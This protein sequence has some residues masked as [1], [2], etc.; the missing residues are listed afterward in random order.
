MK[1][2]VEILVL[3]DL[4]LGS[5]GCRADDL[6][7]YLRNIS[8]EKVVLNGDIIDIWAFNKK[9]FPKAHMRVVKKLLKWSAKVPVYYITGNHDEALRRYSPARLGDL[10]LVDQLSLTIDGRRHWFLHG[11][12]FDATMKNAKWLAKLGGHGYDLLIRIN[13]LVNVTLAFFGR[14]RMSFSRRIKNSVKS[15]VNFIS[16]FE[17]TM[18]EIAL[19]G[20]HEVVVCGHI[21]QPRIGTVT[22]PNGAVEYLNSGDWIENLSALEY[23]K[24]RWSL[25][26]HEAWTEHMS[27][28]PHRKL[29][30]HGSRPDDTS[31]EPAY[32]VPMHGRA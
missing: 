16:D 30:V 9:Y 13:H 8:P 31:V 22:T 5:Y 21:H 4:H 11:D 18:A 20:G 12:I 15:A 10:R 24:G 7:T 3:S 6:L 19:H 2:K 32:V 27:S 23:N 28:P 29:R 14:P 1:R 26:L 25:Y 17:Q